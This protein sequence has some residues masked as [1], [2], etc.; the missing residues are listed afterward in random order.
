M[1]LLQCPQ[2]QPR[3]VSAQSF[4]SIL[5]LTCEVLL[6][7]PLLAIERMPAAN[8]QGATVFKPHAC[9]SCWEECWHGRTCCIVLQLQA[10]LLIVELPFVN[11]VTATSVTL[12]HG[13]AQL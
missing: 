9:C 5:F 1:E 10:A 8:A 6:F 2:Y 4:C 12:G 3:W 13:D 11:R 7:L